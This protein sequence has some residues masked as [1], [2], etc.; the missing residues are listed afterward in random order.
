MVDICEK[1]GYITVGAGVPTITWNLEYGLDADPS[2]VNIWTY[3][4]VPVIL[5]DVDATMP[6]GLLIWYYGGP[7]EGWKFYKKGWGASNTL[8][9]L[10]PGGVFGIV[11]TASVWDIPQE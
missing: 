1:V 4:G 3:S 8:T 7:V 11:P 10:V 9:T 6:D 2:A 5:A